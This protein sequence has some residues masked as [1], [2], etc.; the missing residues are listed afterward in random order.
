MT[1]SEFAAKH[2]LT[3]DQLRQ[4]QLAFLNNEGYDSNGVEHDTL[5]SWIRNRRV[6]IKNDDYINEIEG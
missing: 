1:R 4:E 3:L 2:G 6:T 5:D